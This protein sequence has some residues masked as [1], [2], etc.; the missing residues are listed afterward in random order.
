MTLS[1]T[2]IIFLFPLFLFLSL[3]FL[4]N[5]NSE[6]GSCHEKLSPMI[7]HISLLFKN[8]IG[9]DDTFKT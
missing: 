5:R 7:V 8:H 4:T 1:Y 9:H 2:H 6:K 3:L